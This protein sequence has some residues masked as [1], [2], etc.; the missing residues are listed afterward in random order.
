LLRA[1]FFFI[2][3]LFAFF[4]AVL[5]GARGDEYLVNGGFEEGVSPWSAITGQVDIVTGPVQ[6]GQHAARY[7]G[8]SPSTYELYQ[9]VAVQPGATYEFSGWVLLNDPNIDRVFL[10][11]SWFAADATLLGT[12][13]SPWLTIPGASYQPLTTG[14]VTSPGAAV[15]A[16]AGV[17][18]QNSGA[19]TV[20]LDE[21]SFQGAPPPSP[22]PT[23]VPDTATPAPETT[24]APTAT[25][26]A[27]PAPTPA[28]TGAPATPSPSPAA[29]PAPE[30]TAAPQPT[31]APP[32]GA[33]PSP[34]PTASPTPKPAADPTRTPTPRPTPTPAPTPMV[35][36]ALTNG[37]FEQVNTDETPFGWRKFGGEMFVT[38]AYKS[39]GANSLAFRSS[40]ASTKW[41]YQTITVSGGQ[42]YEAGGD[43]MPR[44]GGISDAWVRISWYE[45]DNGTGDAIAVSDSEVLAGGLTAFYPVRTGAVRAPAEARSA[46]VR[47]MLRP[48]SANT[49]TAYYDNIRFE[50]VAPP[51]PSPTP[52]AAPAPTPTPEGPTPSP[53]ASGGPTPGSTPTATPDPPPEEPLVFASLTNGGF[54]Q[55]GADGVPYGWRKVGGTIA[56]TAAVKAEGQR[57]LEFR[58]A[59]ASTKWA[60][61]TLTVD[62]SRWYQASVQ[63][64]NGHPGVGEVFL[65]ISWYESEDGSGSAISSADSPLL[66]AA[67]AFALLTTG[68]VQA[69]S[70][71]RSAKVRLMLRPAGNGEMRAYFDDV[72]FAPAPSPSP[73]PPSEPPVGT[74]GPSPTGSS[75]FSTPFPIAFGALLNGGFE[76]ADS[77]GGP[78]AWGQ[79][80][81]QLFLTDAHRVAGSYGLAA[82]SRSSSTK[83]AYQTVY[84]EPE[85]TYEAAVYAAAGSAEEAFLRVSWYASE[86]GSG[87]AIDSADS[88]RPALPG[89][90]FVRLSTGPVRAPSEA[91]TARVRLMVR[92]GTDAEAVAYFDEAYF[93]PAAP[94]P[95]TALTPIGGT[96]GAHRDDG[97]GEPDE[98]PRPE[99]AV[100]AAAATPVRLTNAGP[101]PSVE[102]VPPQAGGR[103]A[104][105]WLVFLAVGVS[106]AALALA[107][108][109]ELRR[110]RGGP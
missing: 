15:Y 8:V 85:G 21:L 91:R 23:P 2:A 110:R 19:F 83:W 82:V 51:P 75:V 48:A 62:P 4:V 86:D 88:I 53:D 63:A 38:Q 98:G 37:G 30:P 65:R 92:P 12:R 6:A 102:P 33:T 76:Q 45:S 66:G 68:P 42:Y 14:E 96:A 60:Y 35:F 107:A 55:A 74:P 100:L 64:L 95:G 11:V 78:F 104:A 9:F 22:S 93:G 32:P 50:Q 81:V 70:E 106:G 101:L 46:R 59:T 87:Q 13:D 27:T 1:C 39:E 26:T 25:A 41:V 79:V 10:R 67:A 17:L 18:V 47:L 58:S 24:P 36:G 16:W 109:S 40:T 5:P 56:V 94:A 97:S 105:G 108:S 52:A 99:P 49:V 3:A 89:Q 43:L 103:G 90:G 28:P 71:A 69:P 73:P 77:N 20:Y 57:A 34:S 80:G 44:D 61:Q 72:G 29:T 31:A 7:I 54:E 84:V